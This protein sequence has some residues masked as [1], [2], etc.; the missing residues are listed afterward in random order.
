[1]AYTPHQLDEAWKEAA[2]HSDKVAALERDYYRTIVMQ[3][4][5]LEKLREE[6]I[7]FLNEGN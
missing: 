7:R 5:L 2:K 6:A 4:K 1:M 3:E